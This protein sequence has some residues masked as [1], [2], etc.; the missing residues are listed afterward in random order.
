MILKSQTGKTEFEL[1]FASY[2]FPRIDYDM[3]DA[4]WLFVSIRVDCPAAK[5]TR[6][7]PCLTTIEARELADWLAA[8]ASNGN[9]AP[10]LGFLEPNL[11][12]RV[13]QRDASVCRLRVYFAAECHPPRIPQSDRGDG[14]FISIQ[15][16]ID[17]LRRAAIQL[18]QDLLLFPV[19]AMPPVR[20]SD[21]LDT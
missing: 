4:N 8:H 13:V 10:F 7:D 20:D 19:R 6:M 18:R 3:W 14:F 1:R 12:F 2:Q 5:W 16:S 17:D 21:C 11:A 15:L 9:A